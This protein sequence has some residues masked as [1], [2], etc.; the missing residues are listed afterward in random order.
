MG[1]QSVRYR[2]EKH[3]QEWHLVSGQTN[4]SMFRTIDRESLVNLAEEIVKDVGGEV[5][6]HSADDGPEA[7]IRHPG[8]HD[9]AQ[10]PTM[11][12][13]EGEPDADRPL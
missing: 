8:R 9:E 11:D 10:M 6:V 12:W 7:V 5:I 3:G 1:E 4:R 13:T 2:I